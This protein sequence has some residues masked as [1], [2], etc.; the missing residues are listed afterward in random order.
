MTIAKEPHAALSD[1]LLS[2]KTAREM[3]TQFLRDMMHAFDAPLGS[4]YD[5]GVDTG[6]GQAHICNMICLGTP[7][8]EAFGPTLD[9]V[10][11]EDFGA[12]PENLVSFHEPTIYVRAD[13][14]PELVEMVWRPCNIGSCVSC[15]AQ[16]D[17]RFCGNP[18]NPQTRGRQRNGAAH[19]GDRA[20][21]QCHVRGP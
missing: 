1:A 9:G 11:Y 18:G 17:G 19:P 10:T 16:D 13:L 12:T 5:A 6:T 2:R 3:R 7:E 20:D 8:F 4:C 15:N 21:S 14:P